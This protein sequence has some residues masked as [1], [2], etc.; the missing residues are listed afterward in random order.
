MK[1]ATDKK[2]EMRELTE[3]SII[4]ETEKALNV[5]ITID[6]ATGQKGW[7]IWLPKKCAEVTKEGL[8]K[9]VEWMFYKKCDEIDESYSGMFYAIITNN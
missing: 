4:R 6:T 9:V 8:V 1:K 3:S 5:E 2:S 7:Q